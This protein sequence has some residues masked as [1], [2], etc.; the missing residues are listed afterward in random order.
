MGRKWLVLGA[1][2]ASVALSSPRQAHAQEATARHGSVFVDPLGF[3][4]FGPRLGVE[5]GT[6]HVSFALT[7]RWFNP[8]LLSR[9]LFLDD[10]TTFNFSY[11]AG[12]RGRYYLGPQLQGGHFGLAL[13]YLHTSVDDSRSLIVTRQ[14]YLV[15]YSE[16]GYRLAFG[17]LYG[18]LSAGLG[19]AKRLSGKVDNLPGGSNASSY[20]ALDES[21][22]YATASLELGYLF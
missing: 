1:I 12:L 11:G 15:P 13:E 19:Y 22:V 10:G 4:L 7:A 5:A 8:G 18:D 17:D 6:G 3:A 21:S 20:H 9:S 2:L 16:G 14:S